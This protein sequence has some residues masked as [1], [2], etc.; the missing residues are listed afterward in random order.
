[1]GIIVMIGRIVTCIHNLNSNNEL[2]GIHFASDV[3]DDD[4]RNAYGVYF[5]PEIK[6]FIAENI[7]K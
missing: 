7:D 4:N 3:K 6:K 1:Y 5:T 2:V